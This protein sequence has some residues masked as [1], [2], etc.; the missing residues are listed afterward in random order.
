ME[1]CTRSHPSVG[2]DVAALALRALA[3]VLEPLPAGRLTRHQHVL[4]RLGE[5]VADAESAAA[6]AARGRRRA[7]TATLARR[8]T[9]GSTA[10]GAG[11]DAPRLRPRGRP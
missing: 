10:D 2:A 8:P 9:A 3:G 6:L 5:L 11:R 7:A 4:F 1:R